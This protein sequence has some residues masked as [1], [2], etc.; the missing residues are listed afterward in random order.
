MRPFTAFRVKKMADSSPEVQ[1]LVTRWNEFLKKVEARY[2]DVLKQTEAPLDNVIANLQ[3]DNIIIHNISNGLKNQT[4]TQLSE[5]V[6][7]A[8]TKFEQEMRNAGASSGPSR[9]PTHFS[10]RHGSGARR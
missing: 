10:S 7:G 2:F 5:K 3:Y 1:A 4:V 6:D 9:L 8:A